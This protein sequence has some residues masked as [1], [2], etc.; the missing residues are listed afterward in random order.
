MTVLDLSTFQKYSK[1]VGNKN[2]SQYLNDALKTSSRRVSQERAKTTIDL[3]S[4]KIA[5]QITKNF[6]QN[7]SEPDKQTEEKLLEIPKIYIYP[8]IKKK[9][10]KLLMI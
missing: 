8:Y 4:K 6:Q 2:I 10:S 9:D 7:F 5:N 1:F 3:F